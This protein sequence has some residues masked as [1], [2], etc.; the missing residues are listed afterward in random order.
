ML[1]LELSVW[2]ECAVYTSLHCNELK[3]SACVED[4]ALKTLLKLRFLMG[5]T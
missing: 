5:A 2:Y 4:K 1:L 3:W